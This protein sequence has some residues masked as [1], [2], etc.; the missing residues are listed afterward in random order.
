MREKP[1]LKTRTHLLQEGSCL[2]ARLSLISNYVRCYVVDVSA[3]N[4]PSQFTN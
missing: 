2:P 4:N 3:V 1:E